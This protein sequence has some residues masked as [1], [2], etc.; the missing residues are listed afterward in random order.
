[1]FPKGISFSRAQG[2]IF[3]FH[4]KL[5]GCVFGKIVVATKSAMRHVPE[6]FSDTKLVLEP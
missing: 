1:M 5:Q 4:V 6:V 2:A 3:M